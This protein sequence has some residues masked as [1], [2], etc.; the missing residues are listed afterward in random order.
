[1]PIIE[2]STLYGNLNLLILKMLGDGPMHGLG[3]ARRIRQL[4]EEVLQVEEGALYPAL[5]R[6]ERD[7]YLS[8]RWG[9][10]E[11]NRRAKYYELTVGGR[12]HLAA[13]L[14]NWVRHTRAVSRVL[15][16]AEP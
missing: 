15:N 13:E 1:M 5:H 11:Q 9:I 6:L 14:E 3:I 4:S 12:K 10:S 8:A 16:V 7:G 2:S